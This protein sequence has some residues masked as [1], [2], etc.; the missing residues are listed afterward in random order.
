MSEVRAAKGPKKRGFLTF[1]LAIPFC[2]QFGEEKGSPPE[3][4][5]VAEVR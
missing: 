5:D 3:G 2:S 1:F 4:A